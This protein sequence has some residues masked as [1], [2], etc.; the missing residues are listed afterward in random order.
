MLCHRWPGKGVRYVSSTQASLRSDCFK[1][2]SF[3][4]LG[5]LQILREVV[6]AHRWKLF[7]L[8]AGHSAT[9]CLKERPSLAGKMQ[10]RR[11]SFMRLDC[12]KYFS[13][14]LK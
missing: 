4:R 1:Y 11:E 13:L 14:A 2:F 10:V 6:R 12:F 5:L 9:L 3:M 7:V 8:T